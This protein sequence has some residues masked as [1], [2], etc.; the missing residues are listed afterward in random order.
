MNTKTAEPHV[1]LTY[2]AMIPSV[3]W[4]AYEQLRVLDGQG[5][6][7]LRAREEKTL[8]AQDIAW[9]D[10]VVLC[11]ADT[12]FEDWLSKHC[13]ALGRKLIYLLD[14][15]LQNVPQGLSSS[16]YYRDPFVQRTR[17]RILGRCDAL[18]TPSPQLAA[19]YDAGLPLTLMVEQ[20]AMNRP[21]WRPRKDQRVHIGFCG[22]ADRAADVES[23]LG[24]ML[25]KL[26]EKYGGRISVEFFGA[27]PPVAKKLG[28]PCYPYTA[29]AEAYY[30]QM[31][32]LGWDI[33][34]APLP[35]SP[36]YQCKYYNKFVE[37]A[38]YGIA[39]VY[40][41]L[42]P[43]RDVVRDGVDGLLCGNTPDAWLDSLT[44][45]IEDDGLRQR[46]GQAAAAR[47]EA[48]APQ[49]VAER[50]WERM[51]SLHAF[52]AEPGRLSSLRL[53]LAKAIY[54]VQL[55][56]QTIRRHGVRLVPLLWRRLKGV[57]R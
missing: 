9:A 49:C 1:L 33:G 32:S 28:L 17:E 25:P 8:R 20:P 37:Y 42:P 36:F 22:S 4:F 18:L 15:D 11:R 50:L 3:R 21:G 51:S 41:A 53:A 31:A 13:Y 35:E 54:G 23:V 52:R 26:M 19:Q 29:N 46:M 43:Y 55:G 48:F 27:Q 34:L 14:D 40:S 45:L 30:A 24:G 57:G 16:T 12:G 7:S 2:R 44:R 6:L 56:W 39:G 38:S 47:A 10:W 5:R